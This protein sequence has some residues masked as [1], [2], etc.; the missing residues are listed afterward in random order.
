MNN[1]CKHTRSRR[2]LKLDLLF[3]LRNLYMQTFKKLHLKYISKSYRTIKIGNIYVLKEIYII[4]VTP[5][6][7]CYNSFG[8]FFSYVIREYTAFYINE[9]NK[10][11][12]FVEFTY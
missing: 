4:M 2:E 8:Y 12:F 11:I 3:F 7:Q 10:N 6:S 1:V 9:N 5:V